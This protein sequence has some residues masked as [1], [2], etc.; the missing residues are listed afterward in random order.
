M[1]PV[2]ARALTAGALVVA[3]LLPEGAAAWGARTH[4]IINRRAVEALP[5]P[6][7]EAWRPLAVSLGVHASDADYR[8]G[9]DPAEPARHYLD[10]DA[11]D[12]PPFRRIPRTWEGMLR[13]Y[14]PV[15]AKSFGVAPWA[16]D[17]CFRMVVLS[18]RQGDWSSA[19]GWAADLGHYVADTHQPL[20]CTVNFDGQRTGHDGVH[21]RWEVHMMDHHYREESLPAL[22]VRPAF[23]GDVAGMCLDWIAQANVGVGEILAAEAAARAQDPGFGPRYEEVLWSMSSAL[24]ER[25]VAAAV[26]DLSVLLEAAWDEAGRPAGPEQT[27][28][29]QLLPLEALEG[30]PERS[31]GLSLRALGVAAVALAGALVVSSR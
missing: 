22:P 13:K 1:A 31:K 30:P 17:E 23:R 4:E 5:G 19:G 7:G 11:F 29:F 12:E 10:A 20:H 21:L 27:P 8:K 28:T 24:A 14:G 9:T 2:T 15:E 18:L 16:I 26:S 6:A 3:L 25:Q